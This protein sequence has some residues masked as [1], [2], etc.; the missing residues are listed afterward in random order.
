MLFASSI[1]FEI[2]SN[3]SILHILISSIISMSVLINSSL[4]LYSFLRY[5]NAPK[6]ISK[7]LDSVTPPI[8]LAA[9]PV[10]AVIIIF[11]D[12]FLLTQLIK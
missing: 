9:M 12:V 11:F 6:G 5:V 4:G 2:N 7:A 1:L 3:V 8:L 10:G